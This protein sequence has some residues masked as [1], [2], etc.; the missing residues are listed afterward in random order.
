MAKSQNSKNPNDVMQMVRV[1]RLRRVLKDPHRYYVP[2]GKV[3]EYLNAF[4]SGDYFIS[5][6]AGA[7]G[8]G[9]TTILANIVR[10]LVVPTDNQYFQQPLFQN[11]PYDIK[12]IRL[13]SNSQTL[14]ETLIPALKE[15]LPDGEY[16]TN[17]NGYTYEQ[18]WTFKSGWKMHILTYDQPLQAF[19]SANVSVILCDEPPPE[20]VFTANIARLR[21]GGVFA[22]FATLLE[23]SGWIADKI[24]EGD[25]PDK[26]SII[27]SAEDACVEHGVRGFLEHQQIE[28]M[29]KQ[30]DPDE[31]IARIDGKPLSYSGNVYKMFNKDIHVIRPFNVNRDDYVVVHSLDP[32][33]RNPDAATWVAIDR[34]GRHFVIDEIYSTFKSSELADVIKKKNEQYRVVRMLIDPS[35]LIEDQHTGNSL[36]KELGR[37]GLTGYIAGSKRRNDGIIKMTDLLKYEKVGDDIVYPPMIYFFESCQ[38]SIWEMAHWKYDEYSGKTATKK[39]KSEKAEDKNDHTIECNHRAILSGV[40]WTPYKEPSLHGI[41]SPRVSA[42]EMYDP[43]R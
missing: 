27:V 9:K 14:K 11:F 4:G 34:Q 20:Y 37:Y 21:R 30:Y 13:L 6:L 23:G 17:K 25:D 42:L 1:E 12:S 28:K 5:L 7:N 19:E 22:I 24:L 32:H 29:S 16:T 3:E 18:L 38:R 26:Y 31:R 41:A 36:V 8:I 40:K 15:W 43:Y 35:A 2:I 33:P 39:N 10:A